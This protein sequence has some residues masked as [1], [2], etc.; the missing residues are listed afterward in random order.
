LFDDLFSAQKLDMQ[1]TNVFLLLGDL[2]AKW[3]TCP[4]CMIQGYMKVR[5]CEG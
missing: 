2:F 4:Y 3:K 5:S 1:Q